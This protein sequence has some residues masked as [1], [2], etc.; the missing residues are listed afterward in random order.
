[1]SRYRPCACTHRQPSTPSHVPGR[2][3]SIQHPLL[4]PA[5][6]PPGRW[7]HPTPRKATFMPQNGPWQHPKHPY[8]PPLHPAGSP[9]GRWAAAP[10]TRPARGRS[11]QERQRQG[12]GVSWQEKQ[13]GQRRHDGVQSGAGV[14]VRK[15]A[16]K[17]HE[18]EQIR[19]AAWLTCRQAEA[20]RGG[21]AAHRT[22]FL[23]V[24]RS[25]ATCAKRVKGARV[26]AI[27]RRQL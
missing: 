10:Q 26:C 16:R 1:M 21:T 23:G 15:S 25:L 18:H 7:T 13:A 14:W 19:R 24:M 8:H 9:P 2:T 6:S 27:N 5:G 22:L 20:C 4:P 12:N 3:A 17:V 11:W